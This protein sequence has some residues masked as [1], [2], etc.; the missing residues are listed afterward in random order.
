MLKPSAANHLK[1]ILIAKV[2]DGHV[3]IDLAT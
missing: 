3:S 1:K 2:D